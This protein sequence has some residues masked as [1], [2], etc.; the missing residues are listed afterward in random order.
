MRDAVVHDDVLRLDVLVPE[1]LS[2]IP[3]EGLQQIDF[4]TEHVPQGGT[5]EPV[6][7]AS[8][9]MGSSDDFSQMISG[10]VGH[11][12]PEAA[13]VEPVIQHEPQRPGGIKGTAFAN[14]LGKGA[15]VDEIEAL[16]DDLRRRTSQ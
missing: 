14:D 6:L 4:E 3:I 13:F 10:V 7:V 15:P 9:M 8:I 1:P 5:T 12:V 16:D 2:V 11:R